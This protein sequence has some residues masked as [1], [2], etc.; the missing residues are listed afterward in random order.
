[1]DA[2]E[3]PGDLIPAKKAAG[4]LACHICTAYRYRQAGLLRGYRVR[5]RWYFSAAEVR[6][7]FVPWARPEPCGPPLPGTP[8]PRTSKSSC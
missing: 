8:P 5:G 1:M 7:L 4:L 6:G 3:V 2:A